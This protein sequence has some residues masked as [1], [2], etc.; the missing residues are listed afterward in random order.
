M[1]LAEERVE[2][3]GNA[4]ETCCAQNGNMRVTFHTSVFKERG[5]GNE[6]GLSSAV[7]SR[8]TKDTSDGFVGHAV[9]SSNP[10]QGFMLFNDPAYHVGPFFRWDAIVWLTWTCMLL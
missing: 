4:I 5:R 6:N 7:V 3:H 8:N 10:A 2:L 9:L 1:E